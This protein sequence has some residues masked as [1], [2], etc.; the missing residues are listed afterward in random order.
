MKDNTGNYVMW[1]MEM[2]SAVPAGMFQKSEA[3]QCDLMICY[4]P[5]S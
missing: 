3:S 4:G 2:K 5:L 1:I